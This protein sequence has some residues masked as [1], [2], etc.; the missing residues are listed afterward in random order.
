MSSDR[1]PRVSP[2]EPEENFD[3]EESPRSIFSA[4]WFRVVLVVLAVGVVGAVSVP[5]VLDVVNPPG[6]AVAPAPP[7]P[8]ASAPPA[9]QASMPAPVAP[10]PSTP[11]SAASSEGARPTAAPE[12]PAATAAE[13]AKPDK[14]ET[15][16]PS[17]A[18]PAAKKEPAVATP[19][20]EPA[21]KP[22]VKS[23]APAERVAAARAAEPARPRATESGEFFVQ[24][25]AFKDA[26][27]ARRVAARL[28]EANYHVDVSSTR[29]G[30]APSA[31]PRATPRV[32]GPPGPDRYDVIVSGGST[33]DINTRLAAKGL[34]SEP[35]GES[36][37]I[38]PSLPL[39]DAVALSKDLG[40]EGFKV[41]VRR[42]GG[43]SAEPMPP[44]ATPAAEANGQTL[45]RVRVGGYA[46]RGAAVAALKELQDKGYQPFIARGRE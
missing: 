27:T 3:E 35:A 18:T 10:A 4:T 28:R 41:Q 8:A 46:D 34:A 44:A 33:A 25:G 22:A 36:V 40:N 2:P 26:E 11:S 15:A 9:P 38:R 24:V 20:R 19:K 21:E 7:R 17:P 39:R 29:V 31:S 14:P 13:P 1:E 5:Y 30:G 6:A 16:K 12:K 23:P 43:A 42:G 45:H 37:R 32:T